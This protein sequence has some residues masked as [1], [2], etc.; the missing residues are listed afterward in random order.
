MYADAIP[1]LACTSHQ[2]TGNFGLQSW[3]TPC[4]DFMLNNTDTLRQLF[5][6]SS[7]RSPDDPMTHF[8]D[9]EKPM[10]S[11]ARRA[12]ALTW[13]KCRS[14]APWACAWCRP[15]RTC[16]AIPRK[17]ASSRPCA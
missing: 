17:T 11:T 15:S 16:K 10:P 14:M 4:R 9:V 6:G 3:L 2:N 7:E 5:T 8:K 13:H 12:S 1:G